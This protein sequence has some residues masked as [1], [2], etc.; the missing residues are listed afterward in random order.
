MPQARPPMRRR[1][2]CA[3]SRSPFPFPIATMTRVPSRWKE[4]AAPSIA[5]ATK[6]SERS[7][8]HLD[9]GR[10]DD[11]PPLVDLGLVVGFQRRRRLLVGREDDEAERFE[12]AAHGRV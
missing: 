4:A 5:P 11:R 1:N 12:P 10:L 3:S 8:A 7:L 9:A 6:T 2:T